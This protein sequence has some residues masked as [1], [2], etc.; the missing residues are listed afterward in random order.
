MQSLRQL[1]HPGGVRSFLAD[2]KIDERPPPVLFA[3]IL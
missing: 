2:H 1:G 3:I